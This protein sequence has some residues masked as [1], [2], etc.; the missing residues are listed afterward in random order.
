MKGTIKL[1]VLGAAALAATLDCHARRLRAAERRFDRLWR[2]ARRCR[3]AFTLCTSPA[4][5][6][7]ALEPLKA[8]LVSAN[9]AYSAPLWLVWSTPGQIAGWPP[10]L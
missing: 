6:P 5:A 2:S 4:T 3:K 8:L 7:A 9:L 10:R 1:A